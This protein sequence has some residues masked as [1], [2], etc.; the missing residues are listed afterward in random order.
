MSQNTIFLISL[1]G[2]LFIS[3]CY[4]QCECGGSHSINLPKLRY[5]N[6]SQGAHLTP[7]EIAKFHSLGPESSSPSKSKI[8]HST[9]LI[10]L[11]GAPSP[12]TAS[13]TGDKVINGV[14]QDQCWDYAST[15]SV[16]TSCTIWGGWGQCVSSPLLTACASD[17]VVNNCGGSSKQKCLYVLPGCTDCTCGSIPGYPGCEFIWS[18]VTEIRDSS[19]TTR[20]SIAVPPHNAHY[21]QD[22]NIDYSDS[23]GEIHL[24]VQSNGY[25]N[26]LYACAAGYEDCGGVYATAIDAMFSFK[27]NV[28]N[29]KCNNHA[30]NVWSSTTAC[31]CNTGFGGTFCDQCATDYYT[32]PTCTYCLA[33]TTCSGHGTCSSTATCNCFSGFQGS[34]CNECLQDGNHY[35]YPACRYEYFFSYI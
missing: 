13:Y 33:S 19:G 14:T 28:M 26:S 4:A 2:L 15:S 31:L 18:L 3:E 12:D 17:Y 7:A 9:S 5:N 6:S 1:L 21:W 30:S 25:L 27:C 29:I 35:A 20:I 16:C 23:Y 32:Y 8:I 11:R 34:S 22:N 10:K 24:G